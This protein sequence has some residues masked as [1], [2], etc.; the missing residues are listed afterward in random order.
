MLLLY[1]LLLGVL[2]A[3]TAYTRNFQS[4]VIGLGH[5]IPT[6]DASLMPWRQGARTIALVIAWPAAIG[7]GMVFVAWWKAVMLVVGAFLILVPLTGSF[8]PRPMSGHYLGR[9]RADLAKRISRGAKNGRRDAAKLQAI[10]E[11]LEAL[12][13]NRRQSPPHRPT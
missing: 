13:P 4:T 5:Q 11:Q 7:L 9:I 3:F 1:I 6:A 8:T 2:A 10:L 12:S